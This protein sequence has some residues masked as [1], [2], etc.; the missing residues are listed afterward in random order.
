MS[1]DATDGIDRR[2]PKERVY[3]ELCTPLI[4]QLMALADEHGISL[5]LNMELDPDEK[6]KILHGVV[7]GGPPPINPHVREAVRLLWVLE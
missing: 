7:L 6:G 1:E 4:D 3:D 2:G 5:I